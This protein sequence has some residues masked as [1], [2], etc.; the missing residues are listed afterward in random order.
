MQFEKQVGSTLGLPYDYETVMHYPFNAFA[1]NR[2]MPTMVPKVKG[3]RIGQNENL[4]QLDI[5]RIKKAYKCSVA[6]TGKI[7]L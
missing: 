2:E 5:V 1:V 7:S 3:A 4:S 6:E